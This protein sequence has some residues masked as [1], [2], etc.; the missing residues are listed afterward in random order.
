VGEWMSGWV[1]GEHPH[2][3]KGKGGVC[4][5]EIRIGDNI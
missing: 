2:R 1:G 5:E 4:G 3:S